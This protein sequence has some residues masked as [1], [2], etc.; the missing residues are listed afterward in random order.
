MTFSLLI[1]YCDHRLKTFE[2]SALPTNLM[3]IHSTKVYLHKFYVAFVSITF[4]SIYSFCSLKRKY[5]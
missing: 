3:H 1:V 2:T 5:H 4:Q